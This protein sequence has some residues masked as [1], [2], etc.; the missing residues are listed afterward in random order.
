[1]AGKLLTE[2][3]IKTLQDELEIDFDSFTN[4]SAMMIAYERALETER[5]DA[6]IHDPFAKFFQGSK[7]A[8]LSEQFGAACVHFQFDGWVEFH[9]MWTAVRTKFIDDELAKA[10]GTTSQFVNL[11]AGLDTRCLRLEC[12]KSV[13]VA[14]EVDM[15]VI[16]DFKAKILPKL[17]VTPICE[18]VE[19]L[20]LD[21]LDEEKTL[22]TELPGRGLDLQKPTVFVAEGLVQ[23]LGA[24]KIKLLKDVADVAYDG[25]VF[26]LQYLDDSTL[27]C[28]ATHGLSESQLR[29][30]LGT[31][32]D[33]QFYKFGDDA[34]NFGRY[35]S[36]KF[37]PNA[38]FSFMVAKKTCA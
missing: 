5:D 24:G 2:E 23:Y 21:F 18:K 35:N 4:D 32:W 15:Q 28:E 19:V 26:I 8:S 13:N 36:E 25:S 37:Q 14:F 38:M 29:E 17:G 16:N 22:K 3:E 31:S 11:G 33:F 1:M 27:E 10:C 34:L 20:A 9:K 6:L 30:H 7:G 12:L